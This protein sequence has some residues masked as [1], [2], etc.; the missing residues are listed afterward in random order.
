M[1]QSNVMLQVKL[2]I[3]I[4]CM[5]NHIRNENVLA[6]SLL[7]TNEKRLEIFTLFMPYSKIVHV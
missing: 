2:N 4:T 5:A 1:N 3:Y 7:E 6:I